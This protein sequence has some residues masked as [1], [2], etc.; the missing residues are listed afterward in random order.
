MTI[1]KCLQE[2]QSNLGSENVLTSEEDLLCYSYDASPYSSMPSGIVVVSNTEDVST[3]LKIASKYKVPIVPRGAGT[4]L[5]GGSIPLQNALVLNLQNLNKILEIDEQNLVAI[6][7]AGV[8]TSDLHKRVESLGLFYPPDPQSMNMSTLGGNAAVNA[9]G[10]R[11][12]KYG[13]TGDYVLGLE[14]VLANGDIIR[15]GGKT[16]KNVSGYD[17]T[18][19]LV[20]SEGTLAI[21]TQLTLRLIPLPTA[22]R[23]ALALFNTLEDGAAAVAGIIAKRIVPA[24]LELMD[25]DNMVLIE[26][27]RG[28]GFPLDAEAGILIEVDGRPQEVEEDIHI[29]AQVCKSF[30]AREVRL[31]QTAQDA[32]ALWSGRKAAYGCL[33]QNARSVFTEDATVPRSQLV[34]AVRGFQELARKYNLSIPIMGHSG[35][36]NLHPTI[37]FDERDPAETERVSKCIDEMFEVAL[38]LGGT[39]SGEHGIGICKRD[40]IPWEF[41]P[42]GTRILHNIKNAFDPYGILNPG[43]VLSQE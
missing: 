26:R 31:A 37:L 38:K 23:T 28:V 34:A 6:V 32:A 5:S 20:G 15:S 25:Q 36:G 16:I 17:L 11:C 12:F 40:Y 7:Q 39:L 18:S 10:P 33:A 35:D 8:I 3:V 2:I 42:A 21:I 29:I 41:G 9:G 27:A 14:A 19:L 22:K 30:G 1:Q 4:S 24:T 43:K 13:V